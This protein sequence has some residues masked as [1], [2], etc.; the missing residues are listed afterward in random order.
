MAGRFFWSSTS[1]KIGRKPTYMVFFILGAL[2]FLI[3]PTL[4]HSGS[5]PLFVAALCLVVSMYGGGFA[6][7][8]AYLRDLFGP[9]NVGAIHGRLLLAWSVAALVGPLVLNGISQAQKDAGVRPELA[10]DNVFYILAGLLVLGFIANWL[11]RPVDERHWATPDQ[12]KQA[13][14]T[15]SGARN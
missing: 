7:I 5:L 15:P 11:V 2:L 12:I 13:K 3:I 8:P 1:D 9:L 10:Y 14:I 4:G 6:T